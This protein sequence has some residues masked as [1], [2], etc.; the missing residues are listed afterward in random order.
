MPKKNE[1]GINI[2]YF[3]NCMLHSIYWGSCILNLIF[4]KMKIK[5]LKHI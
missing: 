2:K 5:Q 3:C 4:E 1:V